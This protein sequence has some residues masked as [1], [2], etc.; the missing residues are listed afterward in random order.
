MIGEWRLV[1]ENATGHFDAALN[2]QSPIANR[3]PFTNH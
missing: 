1:I 3:Q 2:H